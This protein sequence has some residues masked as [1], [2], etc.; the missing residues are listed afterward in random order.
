MLNVTDRNAV[1][2]KFNEGYFKIVWGQP[3]YINDFF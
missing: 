1:I 3:N 2:V